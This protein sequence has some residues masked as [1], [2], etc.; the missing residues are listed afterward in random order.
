MQLELAQQRLEQIQS[1]V[2][3]LVIT[4][5][6]AGT[7]DLSLNPDALKVGKQLTAWAVVGHLYQPST[8]EIHFQV[9]QAHNAHVHVGQAA[10]LNIDGHQYETRIKSTTR[11]DG[12][13][14][15]IADVPQT[16]TPQVCPRQSIDGV[17]RPPPS[18][19]SHVRQYPVGSAVQKVAVIVGEFCAT[20]LREYVAC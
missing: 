9:D 3:A 5:K 14:M 12:Q 10:M 4:A 13:W 11:A 19:P 16:L 18:W 7:V 20:I 6:I 8:L 17:V 15:A 2:D 1:Q